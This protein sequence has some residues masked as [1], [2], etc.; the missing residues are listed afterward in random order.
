MSGLPSGWTIAPLV[1]VAA[2]IRGVTYDKKQAASQPRPGYLPIL[3]ATNVNQALDLNSEM[4]YVPEERVKPAQRMVRGDIVVAS[5][6][7][8][9]SVVGK[10]AQLRS[11]WEGG[12]GAFCTVIRPIRGLNPQYLGHYVAGPHVRKAWRTLAQGTNINNLKAS[13]LSGTLVPIPPAAEQER[14]VAAI[15]EQFSRLDGGMAAMERVHQ[16]LLRMRS[17]VLDGPYGRI[18]ADKWVPLMSLGEIVTGNTPD[19]KIADNFGGDLPFV[20]P[21]DFDHGARVTTAPRGLTDRGRNRARSLP[22]GAV[23]ATCIGA[24]LGKV[25]LADAPCAT[26]QQINAVCPNQQVTPAYL[27]YCLSRPSFTRE[28]WRAASSTTMPI[29]NKS[30]FSRLLVPVALPGH[31]DEIVAEIEEGLQKVDRL[32]REIDSTFHRTASLRSAILA[33]AFSGKLVPQNSGDEPASHL[34]E[35]I[36]IDRALADGRKATRAR[37]T[38]TMRTKVTV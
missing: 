35:H 29:L 5:S 4:V 31:Q 7:G 37:K 19:T 14:I 30:R 3:R 9:A 26:N 2:V 20:T 17:A 1:D 32:V 28:M 10:S 34:L 27:F 25:A 36:A 21:S 12:F 33:A 16:N 8:S 38:R 18:P 13:D 23:L 6:S 22:K 11:Q 15:E 24:T